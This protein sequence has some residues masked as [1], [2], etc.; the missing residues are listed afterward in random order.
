MLNKVILMGR[1][2]KDPEYRQTPSGVPMCRISIAISKQFTNKQTGEKVDDTT[3]VDC[4]AWRYTAD[5]ISRYF[6][7]GRMILIEGTLKNDNYTDN[8]GVKHYRMN[9]VI[10]NASFCGDSP[11]SGGENGFG[12]GNAYGNGGGYQQPQYNGGDQGVPYGAMPGSY[13]T[14]QA[15]PP[16]QQ[17]GYQ[18]NSAPSAPPQAP[19]NEQPAKGSLSIGN[20]SEFEDILSDGELPF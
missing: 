4:I 2:T 5:F 19:Q 12:N 20:L 1:L 6:T 17:G 8:N 3:F 11:R 16:Y 9:V 7:K 15:P 13:D 18:Q 10:D 14:R